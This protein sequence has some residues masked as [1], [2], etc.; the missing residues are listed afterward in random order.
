MRALARE[1][2]RDRTANTARGA[3]DERDAVF[4][5]LLRHALLL[6]VTAGLVPA[7]HVFA[8][9]LVKDLDARHTAGMTERIGSGGCFRGPP[10]LDMRDDCGLFYTDSPVPSPPRYRHSVHS[11]SAIL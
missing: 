7:I 5:S 4:K 3:A 8:L 11:S 6:A 10:R 2:E 9:G 1:G